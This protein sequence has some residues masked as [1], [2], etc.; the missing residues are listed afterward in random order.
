[1][2][3]VSFLCP[4]CTE[5]LQTIEREFV[6]INN[7]H[8]DL[9]KEGYVNLL[10]PNAKASKDPG[11]SVDMIHARTQ[12]LQKGYYHP[13][14]DAVAT[15]CIQYVN[16]KKG[17]IA[18]IGC[19]EGYYTQYMYRKMIASGWHPSVTG[20]DISK[21]AVR[22][23]AKQEKDIQYAVASVVH[24]PLMNTSVDLLMNIFA[25]RH[26]PEFSRVLKPGGTILIVSPGP[27]HLQGLKSALLLSETE[28]DEPTF[29]PEEG[30]LLVEEKRVES[31]MTLTSP[32]DILHLCM[33]T[34][35]WWKMT[36]EGRENIAK[37]GELTITIDCVVRVF[38]KVSKP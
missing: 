24:L 28:H 11:D 18:D 19:G 4:H 33:M 36:R 14:A 13:L 29:I 16:N 15:L 1:M 34:P 31:S 26:F 22:A 20:I 32:E 2:S 7:H 3:S 38:Q 21:H 27:K 35:F 6:C 30:I 25:P 9:A 37:V 8:F 10:P 17:V 23:A 12:F 5:P